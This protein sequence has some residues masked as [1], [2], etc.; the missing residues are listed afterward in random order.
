MNLIRDI[1]ET[2]KVSCCWGATDNWRA[3]HV[4]GA[5]VISFSGFS[6]GVWF[7]FSD[8]DFVRAVVFLILGA[9]SFLYWRHLLPEAIRRA[10][11][12]RILYGESCAS[13]ESHSNKP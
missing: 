10:K 4:G 1:V 7:L 3:H 8:S 9:L 12:K 11:I 2:Y 13:E 6:A 5:L